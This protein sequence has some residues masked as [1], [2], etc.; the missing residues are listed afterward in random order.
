MH[1][2]SADA[3]SFRVLA[4]LGVI[5]RAGLFMRHA[6][7]IK[8]AAVRLA[9]A[10][11][12][13]SG[14]PQLSM[15]FYEAGSALALATELAIQEANPELDLFDFWRQLLA[16]AHTNGTTYT[17]ADYYALADRMAPDSGI[18]ERLRT[19]VETRHDDPTA[20]FLDLFAPFEAVRVDLDWETGELTLVPAGER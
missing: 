16:A 4:E 9:G 17:Q 5:D 7:A 15:N 2:G 18:G 10:S 19:F 20:A 3:L 11:V 6:R 12:L 8:Q 1:E 14:T 13:E